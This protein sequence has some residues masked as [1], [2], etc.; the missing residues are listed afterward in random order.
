MLHLQLENTFSQLDIEFNK[1]HRGSKFC[2]P[3]CTY[4]LTTVARL[5]ANKAQ[6]VARIF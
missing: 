6:G 4:S 5:E 3:Y 1:D 2:F